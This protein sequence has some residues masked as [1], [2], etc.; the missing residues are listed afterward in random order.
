VAQ[1]VEQ[2]A[3][4]GRRLR[5]ERNRVAVIDAMFEL[6]AQGHF[7]P[8][9]D[10][11]AAHAGVSVSSVFRYF[12]G[13]DDLQQQTVERYFERFSPL[14]ELPDGTG[15]DRGARIASFVEA[16]LDLYEATAP[17]AR[18]ARHRAPVEPRI[19]DSLRSTRATMRDQVAVH[20]APELGAV[21]RARASDVVALVDAL[22]AFEAWD[23]LATEHERSRARIQRAWTAGL[24]ALLCPPT[25]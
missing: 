24:D 2:P 18:M 14:F 6:L 21:P 10:D 19:A 8:T 7:P 23:L 20:F 16:R 25:A 11:L 17:I 1:P 13:L 12:D 9:A 22:T 5:R 3:P 15:H 4:D